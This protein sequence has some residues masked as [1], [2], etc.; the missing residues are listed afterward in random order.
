[1]LVSRDDRGYRAFCFRCNESG[2]QRPPTETLQERIDRVRRQ[3]VSDSAVLTGGAA[4][5]QPALY[6]LR[7]WPQAAKLWLY[8]AGLGAFEIE[9]LGAFYHEG[10]GRVVLPVTANGMVVFWQARS[11]DGRLPKYLGPKVDRSRILAC[12]G[13]APRITLCEDILSAFK[14][15]L[16]GEGW[17]IMGTHAN[18]HLIDRL[19]LRQ[20][21]VN[22]WM[23]PDRPGQRAA[24][25]IRSRLQAVGLEVRNIVSSKDPKLLTRQQIKEL[26]L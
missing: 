2:S 11:V 20:R 5:P 21:P 24:G 13:L 1:M 15:G 16:E 14:V 12:Y 26:V 10:T 22:V 9:K 23:D 7:Q 19:L 17:S 8:K 25:K 3:A 18:D 6:D 4:L